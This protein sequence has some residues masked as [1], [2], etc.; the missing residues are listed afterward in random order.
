M[1]NLS[2]EVSCSEG[3]RG[4]SIQGDLPNCSWKGIKPVEQLMVFIISNL[5]LGKLFTQ[6]NW[7]CST[8]K[9]MH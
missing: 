5:I 7:L 4:G 1:I 9:Q 3:M 2:V 8:A 6:P